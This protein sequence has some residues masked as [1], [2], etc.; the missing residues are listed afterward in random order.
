MK[1]IRAIVPFAAFTLA[2]ALG[3]C[4]GD[5]SA[6]NAEV[7]ECVEDLDDLSGS[8]SDIPE[9]DCSDDHEGEFIFLFQHEGGDDDFPGSSELESEASEAC[10]GDEFED[11]VGVPF[12]ETA[13]VVSY[14]TPTEGSWGEGDRET[15]CVAHLG[16][17]TIDESF[18][19]N[20]DEFPLGDG[21]SGGED[22]SALVDEC[23]GG[24]NAACDDLYLQTPVGSEEER[25]GATC[26]GRSDEELN[27]SCEATLG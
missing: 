9:A 11:Y 14:I 24:D 19:D 15:I 1:P 18:E 25:I 17:E 26:G 10:Q 13:I 6:F 16:G 21:G 4:S 20:G 27:G 7:G 8:I 23:E 3:A 2:F 22:F 12:V 5:E